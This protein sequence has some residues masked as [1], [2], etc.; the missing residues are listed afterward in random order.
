MGRNWGIAT[1]L[2]AAIMAFV[3]SGLLIASLLGWHETE[4]RLLRMQ[5][6]AANARLVGNVAI[7]RA[8]FDVRFPGPWRLVAAPANEPPIEIFN[9]NGR[10]DTYRS[11]ISIQEHL[12]KGSTAILDNPDVERTL[13]QIDSLTGSELTI[14]Q[15]L[16]PA[17]SRDPTVGVAP[18]GRALRLVTTV[19]RVNAQ[20]VAARAVRTVM[21]THDVSSGATIAAGTVFATGATYSGRAR[22]AGEDRWTRYE[23]LVAG[24]GSVIGI[25]YG[26]LPF[27]PF[28]A[29]ASQASRDLALHVMVSGVLIAFVL[30]VLLFQL[31]KRLVRP[32]LAIREAA[33]KIA[34]G[35]LSARAA[36]DGSDE[37][38]E[39]GKTFDGMASRLQA[40][41]DRIVVATEQLTA[42]A[43]QVDAAVTAAAVATQQVATSIGE[44][45]HGAAESA[46]RVEEAT[47][48]AH[49]ALGH[50]RAIHDEV[51]RALKEA[52]VTDGLASEGHA[53]V[54][55]SLT[56]SQGV[57]ATVGRAREVM[58]ELEGQAERI[59]SIVQIIKRIASQ[60]NLLAL[61]AAIEAARAGEQGK[62]F[63]VVAGE[64]RA[65]ADEV[66]KSSEGI[67]AIVEE[68]RQRTASAVALMGEVDTETE[69]GAQAARA[70]DEAFRSIG[71]GVTRLSGQVNSIKGAADAVAAAVAQ[72]DTAI[73]GVAAI[74]QESAATSEEVSALAE[75][76]SA[77][78]S[79]ITNEIHDVSSMAEELR[80]VVVS[81][82]AAA[83]SRRS[84][85]PKV[86]VLERDSQPVPA[87][88]AAA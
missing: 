84:S 18:E 37:V 50:V 59:Q 88:K 54:A 6:D 30:S 57:R 80:G 17:P 5:L 68:T 87:R 20:G 3:V 38:A 61:N 22:V 12:Y 62:G 35:D 13:R 56:V 79:E 7:A 67:G 24:D 33:Q 26:G 73:A 75:E 32:L 74:A 9:G 45:S 47:K 27:A 71:S 81:G 44:V 43:R 4:Q 40:L 82:D 41:N 70:S 64:I 72:L 76:Q 60:T 15:R 51:E 2:A 8:M 77:T 19:T 63:A 31:A 46:G 65:L 69:A 29:A 85:A 1:K 78:L 83:P 25:F 66:R 14:A 58:H 49:R 34:A 11:V 39:L 42:S 28:E 53:Q 21:P 23:P 52:G 48:Q 36:L 86:V 16:P 55:R 10:E